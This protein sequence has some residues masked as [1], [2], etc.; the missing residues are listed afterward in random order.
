MMNFQTL[1]MFLA[2]CLGCL[3][4]EVMSQNSLTEDDKQEILDAHNTLRRMVSPTASNME[5]MVSLV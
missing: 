5:L 4:E 3:V 2:L 1:I